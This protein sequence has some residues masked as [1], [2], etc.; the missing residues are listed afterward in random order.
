MDGLGGHGGYGGGSSSPGQIRRPVEPALSEVDLAN[1]KLV[2]SGWSRKTSD[3]ESLLA[4]GGRALA[5]R[6][7]QPSDIAFHPTR[8]LALLVG[9]GGDNVVA[10]HSKTYEAIGMAVLPEGSS[11]RA[12]V[13]S[14]QG[15]LAY[16]LLA[17]EMRVA[18]VPLAPLLAPGEQKTRVT[19]PQRFSAPYGLDPLPASARLGRSVFFGAENP[20]LSKGGRFA[21]ATCHL[22]GGADQLAWVVATG[23]RQT[24]TL[25][26]RLAGTGPFNW[27]GTHAVLQ[28]NMQD[29]VERMGGLGLT[30]EELV[31]L[32][33]FLLVGLSAPANP[34]LAKGGLTPAQLR[35]KEIFNSPAA[36][37]STCHPG[38]SG[39]DGKL[40]DA[41]TINSQEKLLHSMSSLGA[42]WMQFNTPSL[43]GVY[44][45]APYFHN[46]GATTLMDVL[47]LT[48]DQGLMGDTSG[49]S[50]EQRQDLI[51]YLQTL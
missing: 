5:A 13:L 20:R 10:I 2:A 50:K 27:K 28:N 32:E 40:H 6:I 15:D 45:S 12:I 38:G 48:S 41:G 49:L 17:H 18:E 8:R 9:R 22:D 3:P 11:P 24:P 29:T 33:E 35:G 26:G 37:C 44:A 47:T 4:H 31:S 23:P 39:S 43:K 19:A 1:S 21:C 14:A 46:G 51:A 7:D 16:V 34:H 42:D 25:A 30:K 36:A